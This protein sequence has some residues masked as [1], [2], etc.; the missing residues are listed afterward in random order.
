MAEINIAS[1]EVVCK[2]VYYGPGRSGKT[3]NLEH[4]HANAP[5]TAVGELMSVATEK[6][7]TIFFDLLALDMGRVADMKTK[8]QLYTVPG[9]VHYNASRKIVLQGADGVVFIADSSSKLQ[10]ENRES[11]ENLWDNMKENGLDPEVVPI[12]FQWNKR[13]LADA[14]PESE[15][16]KALNTK[17]RP[18]FSA[19]ARDGAGVLNTLK[20]ISGLVIAKL[21]T[22]LVDTKD[23]APAAAQ[24]PK[25]PMDEEDSMVRK[26]PA[27]TMLYSLVRRGLLPREDCGPLLEA[28]RIMIRP[29]CLLM[30]AADMIG[31]RT[32]VEMLISACNL[33][34]I[35]LDY[36]TV[37]PEVLAMVDP[38]LCWEQKVL[39]LDAA[40][41]TISLGMVDPFD[42][43]TVGRITAPKDLFA[44]RSVV[45]ASEF[46]RAFERH[47]PDYTG[48]LTDMDL[49][50]VQRN[51]KKARA[52][53]AAVPPDIRKDTI[54]AL[55]EWFGGALE[56]GAARPAVDGELPAWLGDEPEKPPA[57]KGAGKGKASPKKTPS[58]KDSGGKKKKKGTS[59]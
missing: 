50:D 6:D 13:D 31:E 10:P 32:L 9:Q 35:N 53:V 23:S 48:P 30:L 44:C 40:G 2:I 59:S 33:P 18:S 25:K 55:P 26:S 24:A 41:R 7:R 43:R 12:V 16:E 34:Y 19:V 27:R 42:D 17:K 20:S 58:K 21:N 22:E 29:V 4:V 57:E 28:A 52:I 11:L 15:M 3:T 1:R 49:E 51:L 8:F 36:Y 39:P 5:S 38:A 54:V 45:M 14:V 47:F 56:K 46:R 37:D